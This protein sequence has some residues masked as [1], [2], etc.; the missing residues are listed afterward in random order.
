VD[1]EAG[2][3]TFCALALKS[4]GLECDEAADGLKA[5]AALAERPYDLVLLDIDMPGLNGTEA[6]RRIRQAPPVANLKVVMFSGRTAPDEMAQLLLAGADDFLPKPFT[7]VQLRARVKAALRLK[8]AQ[9]RSELLNRHLLAVNAELERNLSSR[10]GDL[11]SARS[12]LVLALAKLVEC[13]SSETGAHLLRLQRFC[14]CLADEALAGGDFGAQ[15]DETF[16]QT[17]EACAP[18]HDIGKVALPDHILKKPGK[19]DSEERLQM[20]EHTVIGAHTLREVARQHGFA[21][22]FLQMAVDIARSHHERWDGKGYPDMLAGEDIPLAARFVAVADVYDALRSRRVYK[23]SVPH[24]TA[25]LTMTE[26]SPGH[27]DPKLMAVFQR[28][29]PRFEQVFR[30]AGE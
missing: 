10:E 18:L 23:P 8:D 29:L 1:D 21:A 22:G 2:I 5:L 19:L 27:F 6:M 17:L 9:D 30:D 4:D 28:C 11:L 7:I 25:V 24:H 16:A 26:S 14:R 13:R 12:A 20:Q 15:V 3:R